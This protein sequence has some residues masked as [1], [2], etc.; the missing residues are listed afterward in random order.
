MPTVADL[1]ASLGS[2]TM[3]SDW[4]FGTALSAAGGNAGTVGTLRGL[5]AVVLDEDLESDDGDD[6]DNGA[7]LRGAAST[8]SMHGSTLRGPVRASSSV[9]LAPSG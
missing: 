1:D 2:E 8:A 6:D 7:F 9:Q 3:Q 4:S 5:G